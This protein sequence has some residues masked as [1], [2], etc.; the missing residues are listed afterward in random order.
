M[1]P[2][3]TTAAP[4][5]LALALAWP[6]CFRAVVTSAASVFWREHVRVGFGR[7][8]QFA[9]KH[10]DFRNNSPPLPPVCSPVCPTVGTICIRGCWRRWVLA[11]RAAWLQFGLELSALHFGVNLNKIRDCFVDCLNCSADAL[12]FPSA[13][14]FHSSG[15]PE[16][17]WRPFI[18]A[19]RSV[20]ARE[21]A[22]QPAGSSKG[23]V[24]SISVTAQVYTSRLLGD[25]S[26]I[27]NTL[28]LYAAG[29]GTAGVFGWH[30]RCIGS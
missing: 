24:F 17:R 8:Q 3:A 22:Q 2:F 25:C 19:T 27:C 7:S 20:A 12:P 5:E 4:P 11:D 18:C 10:S 1:R 15:E 9:R 30:S 21:T 16:R 29:S 6:R 26:D 28:V 23:E 14:V 13:G